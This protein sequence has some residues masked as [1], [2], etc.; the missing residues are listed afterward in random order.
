MT[1]KLKVAHSRGRLCLLDSQQLPA[2]R[3]ASLLA[4]GRPALPGGTATSGVRQTACLVFLCKNRLHHGKAVVSPR[5]PSSFW[6]NSQAP[7]AAAP[8]APQAQAACSCPSSRRLDCPTDPHLRETLSSPLCC[9]VS[10]LGLGRKDGWVWGG[11]ERCEHGRTSF[12]RVP[13]L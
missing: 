3:P 9:S 2:V 5:E 11:E 4:L 1:I 13:A 10:L 8:G 12:P 6:A 7:P